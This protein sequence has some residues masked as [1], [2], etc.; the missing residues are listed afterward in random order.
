MTIRQRLLKAIYPF[1]MQLTGGRARVKLGQAAPATPLYE[2][3]LTSLQQQPLPLSAYRGK[4]LL[5]VNTAS[6]C[7]FTGQ[8]AA[9]QEL[10]DRYTDKLV[11][12]GVPSND[13]KEQEKG[14]AQDILAFCQRNYGV[15]FPLTEKAQV[16]KGAAQ[17][18]LFQ[19]LSESNLNG[20]NDQAPTWN[21][22]KYLIDPSGRL[23]GYFDPGVSPLD[24]RIT[25]HL[26]EA[27]V[28]AA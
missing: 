26:E 11:V 19:W 13:F 2:I 16:R 1:I 23:L 24:Q 6:D 21:F 25:A 18:P 9:L 8:Y 27:S 15:Q 17:H 3:A 20:W 14:S 22:S 4:H 12:M 10:A 7:G 5:I 28:P